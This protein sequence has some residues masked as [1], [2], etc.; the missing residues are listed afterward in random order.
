MYA[1]TQCITWWGSHGCDKPRGH[2]EA[3][4]IVHQCGEDD[5]PCTQLIVLG[6][7][8]DFAADAPYNAAVRYSKWTSSGDHEEWSEWARTRWY[9]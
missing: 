1:P 2:V 6:P 4:D 8:N 3:G 7:E 9:S 5:D